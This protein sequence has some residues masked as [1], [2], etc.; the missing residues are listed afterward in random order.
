MA[1]RMSGPERREQILDVTRAIVGERGFHAVSIEAVA[2][3]AGITRP[4]VYEHF[5]SLGGL[6]NAVVR[7][8]S[9]RAL[10]QISA[11]LPAALGTGDPREQLL[12]ALRGYLEAVRSDPVTW[13]LVL[14]PPEGAPELLREHIAAGRAMV[15]ARLAEAVRPGFGPGG[16]SPDPELTARMLSGLADEVA[17]LLLTDPEQFPV[18]RIL[19][20]TRWI[21]D[22]L[23][24][25]RAR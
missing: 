5:E 13:R 21:L 8:E 2:R 25:S 24:G 22:Q 12:V 20:Q 23:A 16:E 14:M 10:T 1:M 4:I 3:A 6:L 9:A 7:R 18:E 19:A 17:R 11:A 15:V